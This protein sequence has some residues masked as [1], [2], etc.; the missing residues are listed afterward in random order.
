MVST[1]APQKE[2]HSVKIQINSGKRLKIIQRSNQGEEMGHGG[3]ICAEAALR[4]RRRVPPTI[5]PSGC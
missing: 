2:G 3:D 5:S 4:M 1:R